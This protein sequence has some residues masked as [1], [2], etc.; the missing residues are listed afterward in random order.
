MGYCGVHSAE[1]GPVWT[2]DLGR[3]GA[4]APNA[5][6]PRRPDRWRARRADANR[7]ACAAGRVNVRGLDLRLALIEQP[8][9]RDE[10]PRP[11]DIAKTFP[12]GSPG[13]LRNRGNRAEPRTLVCL[14]VP[15][16]SPPICPARLVD[17]VVLV[18]SFRVR[19]TSALSPAPSRRRTLTD[20]AA[21]KVVGGWS[22]PKVRASSSVARTGVFVGLRCA[23]PGS[24]A[25]GHARPSP[26]RSRRG[27]GNRTSPQTRRPRGEDSGP[28]TSLERRLYVQKEP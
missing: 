12:K 21:V 14:D 28:A 9:R 17:G 18:L 8:P 25:R 24:T 3:S 27:H 1:F 15:R 10:A 2:G 6:A 11:Q 7:L 13:R 20:I 26:P 4:A 23:G 19:A 5:L 16:C 22:V